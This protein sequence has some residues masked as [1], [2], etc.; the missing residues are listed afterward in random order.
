MKICSSSI[1]TDRQM[2]DLTE[3][4]TYRSFRLRSLGKELT[5]SNEL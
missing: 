5:I 3:R 1:G 2:K 4:Q